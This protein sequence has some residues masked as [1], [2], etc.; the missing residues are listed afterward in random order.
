MPHNHASV[1][2]DS[3]YINANTKPVQLIRRRHVGEV[4]SSQYK[5]CVV[6]CGGDPSKFCLP[7]FSRR[8]LHLVL[9]AVG[10]ISVIREGNRA[11]SIM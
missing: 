4:R 2:S 11:L 1:T 7:P 10:E 8:V 5:E 3:S 6:N 9:G